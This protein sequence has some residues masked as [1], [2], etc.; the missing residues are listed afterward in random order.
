MDT[1]ILISILSAVGGFV[2]AVAALPLKTLSAT[3]KAA[4]SMSRVYRDTVTRLEGD[5][6][7]LR[8][9]TEKNKEE[10]GEL[11]EKRCDRSN[12]KNR[13]PPNIKADD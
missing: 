1:T 9:E 6:S 7:D 2:V 8:K 5:V 3:T 13:I 12:C 4:E 10:I 11:R